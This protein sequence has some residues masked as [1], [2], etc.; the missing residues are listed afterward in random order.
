MGG[1]PPEPTPEADGPRNC[2]QSAAAARLA[3][4][5]T[6]ARNRPQAGAAG[7]T[8]CP[9]KEQS[10]NQRY[11]VSLDG[12]AGRAQR[13]PPLGRRLPACPTESSQAAKVVQAVPP[14]LW[15]RF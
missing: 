3:M 7:G 1:L 11:A 2:G 5:M 10:R 4:A 6:A 15:R 12:K 8:A 13:A 14:A 9:T